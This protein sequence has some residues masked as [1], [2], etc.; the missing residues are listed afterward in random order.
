MLSCLT[1][2]YVSRLLY[3]SERWIVC[4]DLKYVISAAFKKNV[5]VSIIKSVQVRQCELCMNKK[6]LP[7]YTLDFYNLVLA[8]LKFNIHTSFYCF[9]PS[10]VYTKEKEIV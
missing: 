2:N 7:Q 3:R 9:F 10:H 4:L 1:K 6:W 8:L 5:R